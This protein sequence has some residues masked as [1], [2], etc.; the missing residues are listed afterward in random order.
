MIAI[1]KVLND[2]LHRSL[3]DVLQYS[4]A[5]VPGVELMLS[6]IIPSLLCLFPWELVSI[7]P[8]LGPEIWTDAF[9]SQIVHLVLTRVSPT[10]Q[11]TQIVPYSLED[12]DLSPSTR[13]LFFSQDSCLES[14]HYQCRHLAEI[15]LNF[16]PS[17]FEVLI[18][19]LI[20]LGFQLQFPFHGLLQT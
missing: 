13:T 2:N 9:P 1:R 16:F 8:S 7:H 11:L 15:Y 4:L 17:F 18:H 20:A 5:I 6:N 12:L 14:V 10:V 19:F 3:C